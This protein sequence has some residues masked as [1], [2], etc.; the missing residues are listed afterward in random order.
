MKRHLF[1]SLTALSLL[2]TAVLAALWARSASVGDVWTVSV[3]GRVLLVRSDWGRLSFAALEDAGG[4]WGVW[5]HTTGGGYGGALPGP[6][7]SWP[8]EFLGARYVTGTFT[9]A[10]IPEGAVA[11]VAAS[12]QYTS[13]RMYHPHALAPLLAVAALALRK[14]LRSARRAAR[15][16]CTR[17]GYDLRATPG[18]C[19]E[20]GTRPSSRGA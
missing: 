12:G 14:P 4:R 16:L 15:G 3:P 11:P 10:S 19:P 9:A 13:L 2:L 17:C 5:W 8:R 6:A 18:R 20:C 7:T 1:T